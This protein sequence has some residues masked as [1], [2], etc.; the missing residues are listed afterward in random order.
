MLYEKVTGAAY[1]LA[2]AVRAQTRSGLGCKFAL[3][4]RIQNHINSTTEQTDRRAGR[5]ARGFSLSGDG[6][7]RKGHANPFATPM[8]E[9]QEPDNRIQA[10]NVP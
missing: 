7:R 10:S 2:I 3:T 4:R 8:T 6:K 1:W 5:Q 9:L